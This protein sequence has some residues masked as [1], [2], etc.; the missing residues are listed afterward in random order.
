[1]KEVLLQALGALV[2]LIATEPLKE[3]VGRKGAIK[4]AI[5]TDNSTCEQIELV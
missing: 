3:D 5:G 1:M 2:N 4:V